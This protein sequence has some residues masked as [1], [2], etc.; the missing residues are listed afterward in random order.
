MAEGAHDFPADTLIRHTMDMLTS[1]IR[2]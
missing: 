1:S 2:A